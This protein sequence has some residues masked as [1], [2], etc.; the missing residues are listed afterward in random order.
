MALLRDRS[1]AELVLRSYETWGRDCLAHIDGDFA[2]V[3]WDARQRTAFCAR[4]R[5]GNKPFNYHW[6]GKTLSFASELHAILRLPWVKQELNEGMLAEVLA[7]EWLS[8][9]ETLWIGILRLAA[10]QVPVVGDRTR[11]RH[12]WEPDLWAT[13]PFKR[14]EEYIAHYRELLTDT[15]RRLA[16]SIRPVACEVSGGLDHPRSSARRNSC[17]NRVDY[18]LRASRVTRWRSQTTWTPV[19]SSTRAQQAIMWVYQS[20]K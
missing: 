6:D 17:V 1:D 4:D 16:R 9:V 11:A 18:P 2:L 10:G 14:D 7:D 19:K 8:N 5:L 13:P 3:I 20:G 15:V 12:Y